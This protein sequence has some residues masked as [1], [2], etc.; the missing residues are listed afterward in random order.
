MRIDRPTCIYG[1]SEC[2][3]HFDGNCTVKNDFDTRCPIYRTLNDVLG[4]IDEES[5]RNGLNLKQTA[6]IRR[7][8]EALKGGDKE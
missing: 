7:R 2:R 1:E 3:K 5:T 4:I 8:V 6:E